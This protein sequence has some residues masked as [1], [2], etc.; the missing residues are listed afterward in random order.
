MKFEKL[1][2]LLKLNFAGTIILRDNTEV[3]VDGSVEVGASVMVMLPDVDE[4]VALPDGEYT[5]ED[6]SLMV[7]SDGLIAELKDEVVE[8]P[9]EVPEEAPVEETMAEDEVAPI[10]EVAADV[11]EEV[12]VAVAE[13]VEEETPVD[14]VVAITVEETIAALTTRVEELEKQSKSSEEMSEE[15]SA[16]KE[17]IETADGTLKL[18]K[19]KVVIELSAAQKKRNL[20]KGIQA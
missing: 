4:P 15:F 6:G 5:L 8:D 16:L 10:E 14:E 13:I 19:K 1:V 2:K 18:S 3:I 12:T 11:I 20:I 17:K 9:T 7:V